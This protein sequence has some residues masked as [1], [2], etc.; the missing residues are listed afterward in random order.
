MVCSKILGLSH[1]DERQSGNGIHQTLVI[2]H[3]TRDFCECPGIFVARKQSLTSGCEPRQRLTGCSARV[4]QKA[5]GLAEKRTASNH[6]I[7]QGHSTLVFAA[8]GLSPGQAKVD[9]RMLGCKSRRCL[10]SVTLPG[11][12]RSLGVLDQDQTVQAMVLVGASQERL[13]LEL[14]TTLQNIRLEWRKQIFVE[15]RALFDDARPIGFSG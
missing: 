14:W 11:R 5:V 1:R 13:E 2:D 15:M 8:F 4:D 3:G 9:F 7:Q 12:Q 6:L 10:Q